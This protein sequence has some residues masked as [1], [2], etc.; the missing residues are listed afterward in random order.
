MRCTMLVRPLAGAALSLCAT[1]PGHAEIS[2]ALPLDCSFGET[3]FIQNYVDADPGAD[4]ADYAC[5]SL[6]YDGHRGTD[7]RIADFSALRPGVAV[8]AAAPGTVTAVRDG[9]PDRPQ[10]WPEAPEIAGRDCGNGVL[11]RHAD[12]WVTQYCHLARGS[13]SVRI[14][15][16]VESGDR[17]GLVGL[18]GNTQFPHLHLSVRQNGRIV[19]PFDPERTSACDSTEADALWSDPLVYVPGGLLSA[20][21]AANVPKWSDIQRG[22]V[23]VRTSLA[24]PLVLWGYVF[25]GRP[26]D[27]VRM[28]LGG[29]GGTVFEDSFS[30]DQ[31]QAQLF[32]ASGRHAPDGGWQPGGYQGKVEL[33]RDE[34]VLDSM[35]VSFSLVP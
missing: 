4:A 31:T 13:V 35:A 30:L 16:S 21:V 9:M 7:F 12:G 25:G 33:I 28:T 27:V 6:S 34:T 11:L 24:S 23:P 1:L 14:G 17:L 20:G 19:D 32:R 22:T 10:G 18:S 3:C 5:G 26:G 8:I 29:P 15:D 2:L